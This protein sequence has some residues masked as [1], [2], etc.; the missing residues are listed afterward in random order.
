VGHEFGHLLAAHLHEA[1]GDWNDERMRREYEADELAALLLVRSFT[2][3]T[4]FLEKALILAGPFIFLALEHLIAR[5]QR[6][7]YQ[8][9][10]E[11]TTRTHPPSDERAAALRTMFLELEEPSTLHIAHAAVT[12]LSAQ[13]DMMIDTAQELLD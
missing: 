7:V 13:E 2:E 6:E 10:A 5:A 9:P 8:L 11:V 12:W 4:T 3:S 1:P